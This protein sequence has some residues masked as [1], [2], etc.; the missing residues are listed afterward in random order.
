MTIEALNRKARMLI[1]GEWVGSSS[2]KTMNTY[3]PAT[4][5]IVAE[6]PEGTRE[7]V[8]LAVKAAESVKESLTNMTLWERAE[9]LYKIASALEDKKEKIAKVASL[10][11][12]KPLYSEA[13]FEVGAAIQG[14]R[15]AAEQVKWIEGSTIPMEDPSKRTFNFYQPR[16]IYAVITPFNFPVNIPIEYIAPAIAAGNSVV[17]VPAPSTAYTGLKL[18]EVIQSVIPAGVLNVVT[19]QGK[20]VGDELVRHPLVN[21]IGF[22]GSTATGNVIAERG[23]GKAQLMELGG[24]GPTIVLEDA[25]VDL[26]AS[27]IFYGCFINAGQTCSSTERILIH[28]S[29]QEKFVG[30]LKRKIEN[31]IKLGN[32]LDEETTMGPVHNEAVASK[33]DLHIQDAVNKGATIAYGGVR[34][35]GLESNLFYEPTILMNC[36][37]NSLV[38][39]EETFGPIAPLVTFKTK[40][41]ALELSRQGNYGLLASVFTE[42]TKDAY[43]FAEKLKHGIVNINEHS[44][45]WELHVPFGGSAG[46]KSGSGRI[47]GMQIIKAMSDLKTV[48]WKVK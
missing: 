30:K 16:G 4:G 28:E 7:D 34:K 3:N 46:T 42:S 18:A 29:L 27:S 33:M 39:L 1:N 35:E 22:T 36:P 32:P 24:N 45:Y 9:L 37:Q 10:E 41:E 11:T 25:D 26:A 38:N 23:A 31:E 20:E 13:I 15:N 47:G 12:G 43:F 21:G 6:V 40:E 2:G 19:G 48:I 44:N 5:E 8:H 17:W 14:F